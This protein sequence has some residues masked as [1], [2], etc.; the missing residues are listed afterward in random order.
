MSLRARIAEGS[1]DAL[2]EAFTAYR[3][4]A[5][6]VLSERRRNPSD[7]DDLVQDAFLLLPGCA[8]RCSEGTSLG[9]CVVTAVLQACMGFDSRSATSDQTGAGRGMAS[10]RVQ[11]KDG[12]LEAI[13][14]L[15]ASPEDVLEVRQR[16]H[17]LSELVLQLPSRERQLLVARELKGASV[18]ELAEQLGIT[19]GSVATQ[20]N[21][22]RRTLATLAASS[23]LAETFAAMPKRGA[24]MGTS[25]ASRWRRRVGKLTRSQLRSAP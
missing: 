22:A 19:P 1:R 17:H 9:G 12:A 21:R 8:R 20:T 3:P 2:A 4:L 10:R 23:P 25:K 24:G 11:L 16:V 5:F 14:D 7:F 18:G 15:N 6:K 13:T